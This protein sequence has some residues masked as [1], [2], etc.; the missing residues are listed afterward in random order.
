MNDFI[1]LFWLTNNWHILS[2]FIWRCPSSSF[3]GKQASG[4]FTLYSTSTKLKAQCHES[5]HSQKLSINT[6]YSVIFVP[7]HFPHKH[8]ISVIKHH[9]YSPIIHPRY[10]KLIKCILTQ[11]GNLKNK[12]QLS[13]LAFDQNLQVK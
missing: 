12:K 1:C 7:Y 13:D 11:E 5:L 2:H 8:I 3:Q 4:C 9:Q 10:Y 6:K